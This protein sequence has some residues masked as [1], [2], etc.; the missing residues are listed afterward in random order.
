MP[1]QMLSVE[2]IRL[3]ERCQPRASINPE[4][5]DEYA[6]AMTQ[7]AE[8]PPLTVY[9]D[10]STFYLADGFHRIAAAR[11]AGQAHIVCDVTPGTIRDAILHAVGANATHGQRRTNLDKR[12][13]V[14]TLLKDDEWSK[15]SN[16]KIAEKCGVDEKMVRTYRDKL[17]SEIPKA[18][19]ERTY[20]DRYGNTRTMNTAN[21]GRRPEPESVDQDTGEILDSEPPPYEEVDPTDPAT[22]IE[23]MKEERK[24]PQPK[25]DPRPS[26]ASVS[27]SDYGPDHNGMSSKSLAT[28]IIAGYGEGFARRVA[29]DILESAGG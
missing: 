17:T 18:E 25:P 14:E 9:R 4:I 1:I 19:T 8:F 15:W 22:F 12:R 10:G 13:A 3:D 23:P 2:T 29:R 6:N 11:Q 20:T 26:P 16:V 5:I 27:F 7:G 28:S 21:I 24:A